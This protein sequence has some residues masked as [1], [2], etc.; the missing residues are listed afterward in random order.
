MNKKLSFEIKNKLIE[1]GGNCFWYWNIY[2]TFFESCG[3]KRDHYLRYKA[4]N[5]YN[6]M[7]NILS[8]L[9][10]RGDVETITKIIQNLCTLKSIPDANIPDP[11]K[12]K[13]LLEELKEACGEDFIDKEVSRREIDKKRTE[14]QD[15]LTKSLTH[16]G[17]FDDLNSR[18]LSLFSAQNVQQRGF[19]LEQLIYEL[20]ALNE[21]DFHKSYRTT[22]EQIDGYFNYEHFHYL[23][24]V[25]W[26][27]APIKQ[28]ELAVFDKKIDKKLQSTRGLFISMSNFAEDAIQ[29]F[30]GQQPRLILMDGEDLTL[31]FSNRI[32]LEDALKAKIECAV[33]DGNIFYRLRN[34]R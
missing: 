13:N 26:V 28:G 5:K 3:V 2:Q 7:R 1:I 31:I 23:V 8:D 27:N 14:S 11:K 4:E 17:K 6:V 30:S 32:L 33:K 15:R 18:F 34:I 20:F 24:E 12:A 19:E 16:K 21:I 25:K 22:N 10:E 29:A 9:E